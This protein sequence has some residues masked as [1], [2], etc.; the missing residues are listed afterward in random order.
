MEP[1]QERAFPPTKQGLKNLAGKALGNL[2]RY[3]TQMISYV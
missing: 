2:H 1:E 3:G